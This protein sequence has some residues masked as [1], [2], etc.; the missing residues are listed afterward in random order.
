VL[1]ML[2]LLLLLLL[3]AGAAAE[4]VAGV[5]AA[6]SAR[7]I[8]VDCVSV[9]LDTV[10]GCSVDGGG[11]G[12]GEGVPAAQLMCCASG[13]VPAAQAL[14]VAAPGSCAARPGAQRLHCARAPC[15]LSARPGLHR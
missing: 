2:L 4:A 8:A 9:G 10:A 3:L 7:R 15:L 11:E 14:H 13:T 5:S 12:G 6:S 1:A